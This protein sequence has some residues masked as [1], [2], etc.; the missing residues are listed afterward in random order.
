MEEGE[1]E[2]EKI[3]QVRSLLYDDLPLADDKGTK[4]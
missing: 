2:R 1:E 4:D 3:K